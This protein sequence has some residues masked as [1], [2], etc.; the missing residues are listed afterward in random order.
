MTLGAYDF[1]RQ[2]LRPVRMCLDNHFDGNKDSFLEFWAGKEKAFS[3]TNFVSKCKGEDD[4]NP[5]V[6]DQS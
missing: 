1:V 3:F 5:H 6:K 4:C 2:C